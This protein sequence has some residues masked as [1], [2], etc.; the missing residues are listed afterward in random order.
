LK[1]S[2]APTLTRPP[3]GSIT[4]ADSAPTSTLPGRPGINSSRDL[5]C[6]SD[7]Y[8]S[9]L[10]DLLKVEQPE[11]FDYHDTEACER[12]GE[13]TRTFLRQELAKNGIELNED[14]FSMLWS[15]FNCSHH[16][17]SRADEYKRRKG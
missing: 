10:Y 5:I 17:Y 1:P 11:A 2:L 16:F 15:D 12:G 4:S 7:W 9:K 13:L 14:G 3:N 6:F 8:R